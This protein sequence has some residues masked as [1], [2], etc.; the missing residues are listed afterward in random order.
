M[1]KKLRIKFVALTMTCVGIILAASLALICFLDYQHGIESM[2]AAL[3]G[4]LSSAIKADREFNHPIENLAGEDAYFDSKRPIPPKIGGNNEVESAIPVAICVTKDGKTFTARG[5]VAT[6]SLDENVLA[7]ACSEAF[8]AHD[9]FGETGEFGLYFA[10]RTDGGN[11]YL[12]FADA[13]LI[14][15]WES[16]ALNLAGIGLVMLV[17]FF[18]S[19]IFFSHWALSPVANAWKAQ[20]QFV[21]DASHELKTPLTVILANSSILLEH[22][23]NT[24]EQERRLIESTQEESKRMKDLVENMLSL[25]R[26]DEDE[27][28]GHPQ[29]TFESVAFEKIVQKEVL[30]FESVAFE[31]TVELE[32]QDTKPAIVSGDAQNLSKLVG[33]LLDN[34]CKYA[35]IGGA[36][37][38]NLCVQGR[39]ALLKVHNTGPSIP[40]EDLPHIFD[41]FWRADEARNRTE[42]SY[43]LG[44]SIAQQIAQTHK[45]NITVESNEQVGTTFTVTLPLA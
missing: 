16:L 39:N 2:R 33:I 26:L 43:G 29:A 38:V 18:A 25:A 20:R 15:D 22:P 28:Q 9:S 44:L 19:S 3:N 11:T 30:Q 45:G 23:E 40:A 34:G 10:K 5:A 21:A 42:G 31:K 1:L 37:S 27:I 13:S 7:Q 4:S 8:A 32:L 17:I 12:A 36:V 41:R 35:G 14:A 24:I 6:A